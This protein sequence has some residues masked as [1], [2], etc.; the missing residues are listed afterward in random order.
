MSKQYAL[1][2]TQLEFRVDAAMPAGICGRMVGVALVY[3]VVDTYGTTFA[4]GCLDKTRA[5]RLAGGKIK[6]FADHMNMTSAHVGVVR[7][8]EDIGDAVMMTADIFDTEDGRKIKE[9]LQ[10]VMAAR[11]ET[12]LSVGFVSRRGG[13]SSMDQQVYEFQE[14]ELRE[15]S[16]TPMPAV[17]GTDVTGVRMELDHEDLD[18]EQATELALRALLDV[19]DNVCAARVLERLYLELPEAVRR[20]AVVGAPVVAAVPSADVP[21]SDTADA[22]D[23]TV[24]PVDAQARDVVQEASMEE[25]MQAVRASY[26]HR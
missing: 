4:R 7:A 1:H 13:P 6:L 20:L 16:V 19:T 15:I 22:L 24:P 26:V 5:E 21:T 8:L 18:D 17:P 12:G 23:T 25:R 3:G 14:I 11:A 10:A 2:P 9:Y